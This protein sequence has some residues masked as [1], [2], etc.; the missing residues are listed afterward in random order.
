MGYLAAYTGTITIDPPL[1]WGRF[2]DHPAATDD[3][4]DYDVR[5]VMDVHTADTEDGTLTTRT[6]TGVQAAS[7]DRF[8]G[9]DMQAHL[10]SVVDMALRAN[11]DTV[12]G[13]HIEAVGEDG[14]RWRFKVVNGFNGPVV[15]E[16]RPIL[17]WPDEQKEA[18]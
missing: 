12:F 15:K 10:Q 9:Y 8:K 17:V 16:L 5:F 6:A 2:K 14:E 13:G 4:Y 11:P 18:A 7:D 1:K 3:S